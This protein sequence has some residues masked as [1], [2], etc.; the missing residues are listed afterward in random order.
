MTVNNKIATAVSIALLSFAGSA[1]AD[2]TLYDYT[3]ATSAFEDAYLTGSLNVNDGNGFGQTSYN[4]SLTADYE[5]VLSSANR[6]VEISAFAGGSVSRSS[7]AG[8][9]STSTYGAGV[10]GQ[11]SNYFRPNSKG[12]FWFA[13]A[14]LEG[15]KDAED[16]GS[17]IAVGLGYG[18]VVNATPMAKALRLVEALREV[19]ELKATPSKAAHQQM[20]SIIDRE[21]EYI[22]KHGGKLYEKFWFADI[23]RALGQGTLG[24]GAVIEAYNVL[25][26]EKISTRQIGWKVQ[27]GLAVSLTT[28]DGEDAGDPGLSFA[29]EYHKPLDLKTQFSNEADLL[30]TYG[31]EDRYTFVNNMSL[32]YE[33]SDKIDWEN[34]WT[35]SHFD[36]GPN[37][38]TNH[39]F[40]SSFSYELDNQLDARIDLRLDK[41]DGLD[42]VDAAF[43]VGVG[44]RLR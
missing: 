22:A 5:R 38:A 21:D 15:V 23:E 3:E 37:D 36:F 26:K 11:V 29:A 20:A 24:A 17:D 4:A 13:A 25:T 7:D 19:G 42:D 28:L 39:A 6:D 33:L 18:R 14:N 41:T 27:A 9:G 44:Y 32:T 2:V 40:V 31:D 8:A 16:L 34:T 35:L 1:T 43:V 10:S 12:A 30:T